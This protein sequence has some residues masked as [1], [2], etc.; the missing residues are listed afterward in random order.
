V[1]SN[2]NQTALQWR[3]DTQTLEGWTECEGR[4][5]HV[6]IPREMIHSLLMYNDALEWEIEWHKDDIVQRLGSNILQQAAE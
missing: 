5:I 1:S 3:P 6:R 2:T 4:K